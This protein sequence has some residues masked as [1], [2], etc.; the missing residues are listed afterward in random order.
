MW[1]Y[2]CRVSFLIRLTTRADGA[3]AGRTC[4]GT[5]NTSQAYWTNITVNNSNRSWFWM[6]CNQVGYYQV[7]PPLGEPAI[8]SRILQPIYD[9]VCAQSPLGTIM[10]LIGGGHH[11]QRQCVNMFPQKFSSPPSPSADEVNMMYAGWDVNVDRLF[12]ANGLRACSCLV[13]SCP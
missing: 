10:T 6:V 4:L 5:Y 2:R 13:L 12:F 8:V 1:N 3:Y 9:E 11:D 7:G